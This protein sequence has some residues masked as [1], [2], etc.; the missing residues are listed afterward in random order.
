MYKRILLP[1]DGSVSHNISDMNTMDSNCVTLSC[2]FTLFKSNL[3]DFLFFCLFKNGKIE[4]LLFKIAT[5]FGKGLV[6]L[7]YARDQVS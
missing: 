6:I 4:K 2:R 1:F 3:S 7:V 5:S